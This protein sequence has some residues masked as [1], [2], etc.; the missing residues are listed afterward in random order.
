MTSWFPFVVPSDLTLSLVT[1]EKN[2]LLCK[3]T[4]VFLVELHVPTIN[5][6]ATTNAPWFRRHLKPLANK[7]KRLFTA[8]T[9]LSSVDITSRYKQCWREYKRTLSEAKRINVSSLVYYPSTPV[10]SG[11]CSER[12]YSVRHRRDCGVFSTVLFLLC[13]PL[14]VIL[15]CHHYHMICSRQC[16][17]WLKSSK[18]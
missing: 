5:V 8:S 11:A 1:S 15:V 14:K 17:I 16:Q 12:S 6:S 13:S 4:L 7:K 9:R 3:R 2:W 18:V 10:N